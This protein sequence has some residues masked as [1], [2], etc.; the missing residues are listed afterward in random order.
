[1]IL[2]TTC[3][4][5]FEPSNTALVNHVKW[6]RAHYKGGQLG[7]KEALDIA[8]PIYNGDALEASYDEISSE[9]KYQ[10]LS[11]GYYSD[12]VVR[13]EDVT[14]HKDVDF[15]T[16]LQRGAQGDAAAAI[17]VCQRLQ[18]NPGIMGPIAA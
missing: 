9:V 10:L 17:V 1:M 11:K 16:L 6:I 18:E 14:E 12:G 3:R 4:R 13:V 15:W 8:R 5:S 7:L 2:I